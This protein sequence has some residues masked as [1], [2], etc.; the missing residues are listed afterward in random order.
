MQVKNRIRINFI[1]TITSD[2]KVINMCVVYAPE[3]KWSS[4]Q[5]NNIFISEFTPISIHHLCKSLNVLL[6]GDFNYHVNAEA[7]VYIKEFLG[8]VECF[9]LKK[10]MLK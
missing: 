10:N 9:G 1:V 2:Q 5:A 3:C 4:A 7:N 6:L 8:L